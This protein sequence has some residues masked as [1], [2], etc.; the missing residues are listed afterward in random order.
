MIITV[1]LE[2]SL[3]ISVQ[4]GGGEGGYSIYGSDRYV[5]PIRVWFFRVNGYCSVREVCFSVP[6]TKY[7]G[8]QSMY[9]S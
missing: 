8:V 1:V 5:S 9:G 3:L 4:G 7:L 6:Y 2:G